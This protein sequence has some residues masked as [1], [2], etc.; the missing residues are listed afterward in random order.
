MR[1]S[2]SQMFPANLTVPHRLRDQVSA[3]DRVFSTHRQEW[4]IFNRLLQVAWKVIPHEPL[5]EAGIPLVRVS[6]DAGRSGWK[7]PPFAS[8]CRVQVSSS[9]VFP[10]ETT[11][12]FPHAGIE[13]LH[14]SNKRK[15]LLD[16]VTSQFVLI[17]ADISRRGATDHANLI[18]GELIRRARA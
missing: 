4:T 12:Q 17:Q 11:C 18:V 16:V 8:R 5:M 10:L 7:R 1:R 2:R 3:R 14:R 13:P 9:G 6:E 15:M